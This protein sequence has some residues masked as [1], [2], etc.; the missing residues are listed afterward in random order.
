MSS[1]YHKPVL[2]DETI[3]ILEP[4]KRNSY[5]DCTTG[6]AGHAIAMMSR[7]PAGAK[8][9]GIDRDDEAIAEAKANIMRELPERYADF[10]PIKGNF[11]E[12][13]KLLAQQGVSGVDSCLADLG[14]SSHQFDTP[15]RGFSFRFDAK[16]DMRLD[17]TQ[18]LTAY[19]IVNGYSEAELR[20]V[21][22]EYGEE[23][24]TPSIVRNII[25]RRETAPI[26]TTTELVE[27][28]KSSMPAKALKEKGH[29][30]SRT[31]QALRIETNS[32]IAGLEDAIRDLVDILNPGG[33][34]AVITFHSLEDRIVKNVFRELHDPCT[35]PKSAPVCICGKKPLIEILL[36]KPVTAGEEELEGNPRA[37]SAKLRAAR[38]I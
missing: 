1:A 38:K 15:E 10:T 8:V 21:L 31:F 25:K 35:C 37:R 17:Q 23:K 36:K 12:A 24:F 30:A 16:L 4:E 22:Y 18:E 3:D 14:V 20:R 2:K 19:D 26:E 7:M 34:I 28:I 11:F 29:P 27:I 13:K 5:L 33:V 9:Y 32:E 6:A